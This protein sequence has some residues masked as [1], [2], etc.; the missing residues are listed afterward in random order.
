MEPPARIGDL[1]GQTGATLAVAESCTG[2]L[3]CSKITDVA[4]ASDHFQLGYVT[5]AVRA[6]H[7]VLGVDARILDDPGPVSEPAVRQMARGA[8][9]RAG[10]D[11]GLATTGYAGPGGGTETDPVG[12]VYVGVSRAATA[13]EEPFEQVRRHELSGTR[14]EVKEAMAD[15]ALGDLLGCLDGTG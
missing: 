9:R 15:R 11:W 5:Y 14:R 1:L 7:E 2:G 4:D 12:T 6:K 3:V 10:T 13:T 8:R